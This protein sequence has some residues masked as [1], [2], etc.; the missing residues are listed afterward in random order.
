MFKHFLK[1]ITPSCKT[2]VFFF[3]PSSSYGTGCLSIP[4]FPSLARF[5]KNRGKWPNSPRIF[6]MSVGGPRI[7]VQSQSINH[8]LS[9]SP[10]QSLIYKPGRI[11]GLCWP[12]LFSFYFMSLANTNLFISNSFQ[13]IGNKFIEYCIVS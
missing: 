5:R 12:C 9:H 7:E 2:S 6:A 11:V 10:T 3:Y 4:F 8:S 13:R 1:A